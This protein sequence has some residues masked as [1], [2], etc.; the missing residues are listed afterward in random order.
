[1]KLLITGGAGFIGSA[2]IRHVLEHTADEVVNLDSL[3]YAGNRENVG[4]WASSP[5]YTFVHADVCDRQR[6][7]QVLADHGPDVIVHL[8]AETHVDRSIDGPAA[9]FQTNLGGTFALL[10]AAREYHAALPR[11]R[12]ERFR[13]HHVSTDEVF[14]ELAP[15]APPSTEESRYQPSSP[16]AATK[17][18]ADHLVRAWFR[19]FALP[20]SLSNCSNNYG[21]YQYPEK[22][23]PL[24]I[25]N[26]LDGLPLRIYGRGDQRRDWLYV[27]DH[28]RAL[29]LVVTRGRAGDSYNIGG[30]SE[31]ANLDVVRAICA[32]LEELAP[33]RPAGVARY[34]DLITFVA[35][36]PGH[37][38]RYALDTSRIA[39]ELGWTPRESFAAGLRKTVAWYVANR[40]WCRRVLDGKYARQR[41]GAP[42]ETA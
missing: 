38:R 2:L 39:R 33:A 25:A 36:R 10:D 41:L 13:F 14:G 4:A 7:G 42:A 35:D 17:A 34:E 37:D 15:D 31:L 27:E 26:A 20:C 24:M 11:P 1:V 40:D 3:T 5:A 30:A 6:V 28:A 29:Y 18:G 8:A 16:Y 22:L 9:F 32:L 19:T 23:I 12:R 21:P